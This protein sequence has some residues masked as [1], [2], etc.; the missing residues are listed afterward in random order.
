MLSKEQLKEISGGYLHG[1]CACL[2]DSWC[3]IVYDNTNPFFDQC[4]DN[5]LFHCQETPGDYSGW[6]YCSNW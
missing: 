4:D 2:N 1:N 6:G 3:G 5:S